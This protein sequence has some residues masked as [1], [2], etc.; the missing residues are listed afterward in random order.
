MHSVFFWCHTCV[1]PENLIKIRGGGESHKVGN[2]IDAQIRS[3]EHLFCIVNPY[4][5][6]SLVWGDP[7]FP[8]QA[9]YDMDRVEI[10]IIGNAIQG[11]LGVKVLK[12]V[13]HNI[14]CQQFRGIALRLEYMY[15]TQEP[16]KKFLAF[17]GRQKRLVLG[18]F[19]L[20]L[21]R[22]SVV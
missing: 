21:D 11:E 9:S 1:F 3:D 4:L 17:Q 18:L 7:V 15:K 20:I 12:Y 2:F 19:L 22:K 13:F 10:K 16:E 14:G 6:D 5:Y 8:F